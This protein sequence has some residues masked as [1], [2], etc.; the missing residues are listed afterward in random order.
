[1]PWTSAVTCQMD[2]SM[3]N[4]PL[5]TPSFFKHTRFPLVK[6]SGQVTCSYMEWTRLKSRAKKFETPRKKQST[7]VFRAVKNGRSFVQ[8]HHWRL[9]GDEW[10][11]LAILDSPNS[12][13]WS[14][15]FDLQEFH[16]VFPFSED[17]RF[18]P[19]E[20]QL[21]WFLFSFVFVVFAVS[22]MILFCNFKEFWPL[23]I[24]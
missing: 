7:I 21:F 15:T 24:F 14:S 19:F 22:S 23:C 3:V 1:M 9:S 11:G 18:E 17:L 10:K 2:D 13:I 20:I 16:K 12:A 8:S 5:K 4:P 6:E